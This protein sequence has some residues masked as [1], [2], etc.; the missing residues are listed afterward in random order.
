MVT[1]PAN[2]FATAST[3]GASALHVLHVGAQNQNAV[4]LPANSA[5]SIAPPPT[6]TVLKFRISG[7]AVGATDGATD[8]APATAVTGAAAAE[9]AA[10]DAADTGE[11]AAGAAAVVMLFVD[12]Q[13]ARVI[14]S[15]QPASETRR[16]FMAESVRDEIKQR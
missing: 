15:A 10:E 16:F 6:L 2:F 5:P 3:E 4:G 7:T 9:G 14:S 1:L 11:L 13:L 12:P 8:A